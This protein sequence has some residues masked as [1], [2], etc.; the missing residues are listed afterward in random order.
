MAG[1]ASSVRALAVSHSAAPHAVCSPAAAGEPPGIPALPPVSAPAASSASGVE[2]ACPSQQ[3]NPPTRRPASFNLTLRPAPTARTSTVRENLTPR[4]TVSGPAPRPFARGLRPAP[5]LRSPVPSPPVPQSSA[6]GPRTALRFPVFPPSLSRPAP[7]RPARCP[8]AAGFLRRPQSLRFP[9]FSAI[10]SPS[11]LC[12]CPE[13][14]CSRPR[15]PPSSSRVSRV[16]AEV[17]LSAQ[18]ARKPPRSP[19]FRSVPATD[20]CSARYEFKTKKARRNPG[21]EICG[22]EGQN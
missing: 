14:L 3:R 18:T 10:R 20:E 6:S 19:H 5:S 4:P 13:I 16:S 11:V 22:A 8:P 9:R 21:L 2:R 1:P 17:D 7:R 15:P 12:A